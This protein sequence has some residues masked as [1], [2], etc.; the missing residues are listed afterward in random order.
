MFFLVLGI[1]I[2]RQPSLLRR[3]HT[4][5]PR[6]WLQLDSVGPVV[7]TGHHDHCRIRYVHC[8]LSIHM[9]GL[10]RLSYS[11]RSI[12]SN[13]SISLDTL[14]T[15]TT[16]SLDLTRAFATCV[17]H[18]RQLAFV[19]QNWVIDTQTIP[20]SQSFRCK[21]RPTNTNL[22]FVGSAH[23]AHTFATHHTISN[24]FHYISIISNKI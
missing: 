19:W 14:T 4:I 8:S 2:F 10:L 15:L 16:F 23:T 12:S 5:K 1:V 17:T 22:I 7:G 13:F 11:L 20:D 18:G 21:V 6:Q 9:L 24:H 3:T